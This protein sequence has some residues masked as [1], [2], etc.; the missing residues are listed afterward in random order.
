MF[1]KYAILY[2]NENIC[3]LFNRFTKIL[4][5]EEQKFAGENFMLLLKT[6]ERAREAPMQIQ[7]T[8]M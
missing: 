7:K 1:S 4:S 8:L 3:D 6:G 5:P 2:K